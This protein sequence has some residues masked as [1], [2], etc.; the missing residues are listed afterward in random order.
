MEHE[1]RLMY[2]AR[3]HEKLRAKHLEG[4]FEVVEK[5]LNEGQAPN[6]TEFY[7]RVK[8]CWLINAL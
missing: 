1:D 3:N 8:S 6:R 7:Y 2:I 4:I 5:G